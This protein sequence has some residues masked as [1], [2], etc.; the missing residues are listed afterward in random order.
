MKKCDQISKIHNALYVIQC[1]VCKS[2]LASASERD[3]M[4]EFSTCDD[5]D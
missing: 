3:L 5:C 1:P 4:P 2:I